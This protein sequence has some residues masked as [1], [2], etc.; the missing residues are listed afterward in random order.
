M[1]ARRNPPW[2]RDELILALDLYFRVDAGRVAASDQ[3]V[4]ELSELLN[5][6]PIH[7][8]RADAEGFRNPNGVKMKLM[9]LR[10]ADPSYKGA[11]LTHGSELEA[12]IWNEFAGDRD[13]LRK[14]ANTIRRLFAQANAA[15]DEDEL[16]FQE[17]RISYRL[18]RARERDAS[19]TRRVTTE[20]PTCAVCGFSFRDRYGEIGASFI[21]V[22][23]TTKPE[24]ALVR[25]SSRPADLAMVCSNCHRMLHRRRPWLEKDALPKLL[26]PEG[27]FA[28]TRVAPLRAE[29]GPPKKRPITDTKIVDIS[30]PLA[31]WFRQRSKDP[32]IEWPYHPRTSDLS[33]FV[34]RRVLSDLLSRSKHLAQS[35]QAGEIVCDINVKLTGAN[36]RTKKLDLI[37]GPPE[38]VVVDQAKTDEPL[39][40][41]R[42]AR[43][44]FSLEIKSC[45]TEHGKATPRLVDE[46]LSS[47]DVARSSS[48]DATI[49]GL[50]LVN[51]AAM[52]TS[53]LNL[54]GPNVHTQPSAADRVITEIRQRVPVGNGGYDGLAI[55]VLDMDNERRIEAVDPAEWV[56]TSYQYA[57]VIAAM[58]ERCAEFI[59]R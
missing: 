47:L 26:R 13:R 30:V 38:K 25:T 42:V 31:D 54:P 19:L 16:E 20:Q 32:R 14:I 41:A 33:D 24:D 51:T 23:D 46:M 58:A 34:R 12:V 22:H 57:P 8:D 48:P 15:I 36:G 18:H 28:E 10:T 17:G 27:R 2:Q 11:G 29:D 50:L 55:A 45:M 6:L 7:D 59:G 37:V 49:M 35:A 3:G 1:P 53:P 39:R 52:F 43:P 4:V 5:R 9:N 44:A 56:P 40:K 21:E